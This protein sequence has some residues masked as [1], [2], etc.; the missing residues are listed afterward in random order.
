MREGDVGRAARVSMV[1]VM[2]GSPP[3]A[4]RLR[5]TASPFADVALALLLGVLSLQSAF[6]EQ[7]RE[8]L[9][10]FIVLIELAVLPLAVRRSRPLAVLAITLAAAI[11]GDLLFSSFQLPGPV[12]ALYTVAAHCERRLAMTAAAVDGGGAGDP[13]RQRG[14][15]TMPISVSRRTRSSLRRGRSGIACARGALT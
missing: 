1:L 11:A 7:D 10:A 5:W 14:R 6:G 8:H 9:W 12:I 3:T 4:R 15:W 13:G 2:S